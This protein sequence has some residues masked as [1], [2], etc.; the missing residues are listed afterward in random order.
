MTEGKRPRVSKLFINIPSHS[1]EDSCKTP[2]QILANSCT[3]N[4]V[5]SRTAFSNATQIANQFLLA[6]SQMKIKS[7]PWELP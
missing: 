5:Y 3:E 6:L 1:E 7:R 2:F 4:Q